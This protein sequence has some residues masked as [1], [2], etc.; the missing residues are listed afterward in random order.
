MIRFVI[1]SSIRFVIE[2]KIKRKLFTK[3]DTKI[4]KAMTRSL[5]GKTGSSQ[6]VLVID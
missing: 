3:K 5:Q 4:L 2:S 1:E 6:V